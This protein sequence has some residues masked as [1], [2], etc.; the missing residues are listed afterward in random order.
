MNSLETSQQ[1]VRYFNI[2]PDMMFM[3]QVFVLELEQRIKIQACVKCFLAPI[4]IRIPDMVKLDTREVQACQQWLQ[5]VKEY[6]AEF[7]GVEAAAIRVC[8]VPGCNG[9]AILSQ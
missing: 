3:P 1:P 4:E 2:P 8:S 5:S 7:W 6:L 9:L